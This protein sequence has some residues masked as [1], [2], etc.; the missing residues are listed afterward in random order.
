MRIQKPL[1]E[2]PNICPLSCVY[3]LFPH[4]FIFCV[5]IFSLLPGV[6]SWSCNYFSYPLS[7]ILYPLSFI[8]YPLSFILYPLLFICFSWH[9]SHTMGLYYLTSDSGSL[10]VIFDV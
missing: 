9:L 7:F 4:F 1:Y 2:L 6:F 10:C 3:R 5:V 8:L